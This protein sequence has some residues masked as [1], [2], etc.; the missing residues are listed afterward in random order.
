[1]A[2]NIQR[3]EVSLAGGNDENITPFID[4]QATI[5]M[6]PVK[7]PDGKTGLI[8]Y[9]GTKTLYER[10]SSGQTRQLKHYRKTNTLLA[11]YG[12]N[13]FSHDDSLVPNQVSDVDEIQTSI[14]YVGMAENNQGQM[15][16]VD[17]VDVWLL[18][19]NPTFSFASIT[20]GGVDE[21]TFTNPID[22]TY[23]LGRTFI[24]DSNKVYGSDIENSAVFKTLNDIALEAQ[25]GNLVGL[26]ALPSVQK[27]VLFGE[28]SSEPYKFANLALPFPYIRDNSLLPGCHALGSIANNNKI[29][30]WLSSETS[31]G[32]SFYEWKG[33]NAVKISTPA[34]S[35]R[36][37]RLTDPK[38]CRAYFI[39]LND[40]LHYVINFLTDKVSLYYDF[41]MKQWGFLEDIKR[42]NYPAICHAWFDNRHFIG[43][44]AK[45]ALVQ[46]SS[47]YT[48]NDGVP[49]RCVRRSTPL[50]LNKGKSFYIENM[51][52]EGLY[53]FAKTSPKFVD[54]KWNYDETQANASLR[55]SADHGLT[56]SD[57]GIKSLGA[58]GEHERY[59]IWSKVVQCNTLVFEIISH[60]Y[61]Q[62][63]LTSIYIDVLARGY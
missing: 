18:E 55:V 21:H 59:I 19:S 7:L 6:Y 20:T 29:I 41:M 45:E 1:M 17:G 23:L 40:H 51:Q 33:G 11:I 2:A 25:A 22:V 8:S 47:D 37:E 50:K 42:N 46:T 27:I 9:P 58:P 14:G 12:R 34:Q 61:S 38:D 26:R 16:I 4:N 30:A 32:Y 24:A 62:F 15:I 3:V 43:Y 35:Y 28:E 31:G 54:N 5:N 60:T 63:L 49:I 39:T 48:T 53:G 57:R 10:A 36:L 56:Y 44:E 13:L 52:I